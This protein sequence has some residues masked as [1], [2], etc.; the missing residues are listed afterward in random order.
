MRNLDPE[1]DL[2]SS[3]IILLIHF[4]IELFLLENSLHSDKHIS[5]TPSEKFVS[6]R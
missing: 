3:N 1:E 4:D 6:L 5:C 2:S